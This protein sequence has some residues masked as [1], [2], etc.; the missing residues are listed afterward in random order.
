MSGGSEI[1]AL[2][3]TINDCWIEGRYDDLHRYFH[4]AMVLVMPGFEQRVEGAEPII[5]SYRGFGE[6]ATIHAFEAQEAQVDIVGST[7]IT[8]TPFAIDYDF[9]G[10]R[11][12]ETGIDLLV[13]TREQDGW[14]VRWRT[15][16][17]QAADTEATDS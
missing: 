1:A 2:V 17:P 11:Y 16:I 6:Q 15:L 10:T 4:D 13:F 14:L 5:D 12:R 9:E 7:A 8:A 3:R